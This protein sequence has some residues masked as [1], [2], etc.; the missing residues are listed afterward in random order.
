MG[1]LHWVAASM[2]RPRRPASTLNA[3]PARAAPPHL[4]KLQHAQAARLGGR[5]QAGA[6][7]H[8]QDVT[9]VAQAVHVDAPAAQELQ[10]RG[11]PVAGI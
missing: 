2:G 4:C 3:H 7:Q 5:L 8:I 1:S 10:Q 11:V 9:K 6:L